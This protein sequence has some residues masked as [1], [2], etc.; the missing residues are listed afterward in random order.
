MKSSAWSHEISEALYFTDS[1]QPWRLHEMPFFKAIYN[2]ASNK[3][4]LRTS[5]Q[6]TKTTTVR[7][8]L[9]NRSIFNSNNSALYVAPTG[10]Q[11]REFS[12]KKFD[13][14]FTH[15]KFLEKKFK[16]YDLDWNVHSKQ[17]AIT[18]SSITL[19][20]VGGPLGA[21][22][23]RGGT[24]NDIFKDEIQSIEKSQ[25]P[26][27]D[28]CAA[29]FDGRSGRRKAFFLNAGTPLSYANPIEEE[30]NLSKG[31]EWIMQCPHCSEAVPDGPR[32]GG[33]QEPL[34]M[35]HLDKKKPFLFCMNCGKDMNRPPNSNERIAPRGTWIATN[36][37]GK[38]PGFRV[39]RM[40]MPWARWR[41]ENG[42]GIL[43]RWETWSERR[44]MNEVIGLPF[45]GGDQPLTERDI[46]NCC[47]TYRLPKS[48]PDEEQIAS[49]HLNT[50]KVAG[51]D[52]A[53]SAN[54]STPSFT[55]LGIFAIQNGKMK[56][57]FAHKFMG[58]AA[59]DPEHVLKMIS[60]WI[61]RF[62]V[63][64]IGCDF[65]VGHMENHRLKQAF[66][67]R[68]I[69]F[70]YYGGSTGKHKTRY[71]PVADKYALHKTMSLETFFRNVKEEKF[72]LPEFDSCKDHVLDWTRVIRELS[73]KTRTTQIQNVGTDDF[74]HVSNYANTIRKMIQSNEFH[75]NHQNSGG[76]YNDSTPIYGY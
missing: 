63:N 3:I 28:E 54:E 50:I 33:W 15:N 66:P 2:N 31:Y 48:T 16:R 56:L 29:T 61:N 59:S 41:T 24:Y 12:K 72:I 8:K 32:I 39:V 55:K 47:S 11:V 13:K 46:K 52:W 64:Y 74:L 42:T 37:S 19:R 23:I 14:I 26:I 7:H 49:Q 9:N 40:M 25:V 43:D 20:S 10:K 71:D 22:S 68:V 76:S 44:F 73:E 18:H 35:S 69:E 38:F 30:W 53:M 65:G 51:L 5:R 57:I 4:L 62:Q 58:K 17:Y 36:P 27:I 75:P 21:E 1:G 45:E 34:G 60:K 70:H 67:G 6:S